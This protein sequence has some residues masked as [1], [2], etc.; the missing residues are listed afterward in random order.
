MNGTAKFSAEEVL[1]WTVGILAAAIEIYNAL[2]RHEPSWEHALV[3][4]VLVVLLMYIPWLSTRLQE[5]MAKLHGATRDILDL[6][7][8]Q[9][10]V[11]ERK[12]GRHEQY[13]QAAQLLKRE[14]IESVFLMQRSS[15]LILGPE[16]RWKEEEDFYSAL[17]GV[18]SQGVEFYHVVSIEGIKK[19]LAREHSSFPKL[20][21]AMKKL[22]ADANGDIYIPGPRGGGTHYFARLD[23]EAQDIK[24]DKQARV[25][26]VRYKGEPTEGA[27]VFDIGLEQS[28][29]HIKGPKIDEYFEDCVKFYSDNCRYLTTADLDGLPQIIPF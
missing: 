13:V 6:Q 9:T 3:L 14:R 19:H 16:A 5:R 29:F 21:D 2:E 24:P 10:I 8:A 26:L 20:R 18:I 22:C 28:C 12:R 1:L 23:D 17:L 27:F 25:F 11:L 7:K 15:T 4:S